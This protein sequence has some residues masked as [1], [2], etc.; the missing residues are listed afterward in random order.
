[1]ACSSTFAPIPAISGSLGYICKKA[2]DGCI[3]AADLCDK[4]GLSGVEKMRI[5]EEVLRGR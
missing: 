5:L 1:L 3:V 2:A 4:P